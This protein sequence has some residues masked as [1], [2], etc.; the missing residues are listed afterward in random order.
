M[1]TR[2]GNVLRSYERLAGYQYGL[3]AVTVLRHVA[4]VAPSGHVEYL[5]DQRQLL[6]LSVRMCLTS[7]LATLISIAFLW[8]HGPWLAIALVPY[9]L[10]YLSY[11]GAIVVAHEYGAAMSTMID[12]DRFALYDYLRL[13]RPKDTAEEQRTNPGLVEL[14]SHNRSINL[15]YEYREASTDTK[16]EPTGAQP[17]IQA[18]SEEGGAEGD[19]GG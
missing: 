5:D 2:L 8:H 10:A 15:I 9:V 4:L 1:P 19:Q 11:R 6:D 18:G 16:V 17:G 12:L 7:I 3:D 14:L 13:P